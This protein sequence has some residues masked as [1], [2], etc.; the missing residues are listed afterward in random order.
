MDPE[1]TDAGQDKRLFGIP[2][3]FVLV[4]I[5]YGSSVTGNEINFLSL[6]TSSYIISFLSEYM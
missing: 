2:F 1:E 6:Q 5:I 3:L 4:D